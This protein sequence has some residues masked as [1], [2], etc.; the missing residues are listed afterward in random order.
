[1]RTRRLVSF[2]ALTPCFLAA[3]ALGA[4]AS[5]RGVDASPGGER[6]GHA[7]AP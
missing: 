4:C 5:Y 3:A 2:S 6:V 7:G 1:M